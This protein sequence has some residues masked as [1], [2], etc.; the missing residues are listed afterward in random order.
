MSTRTRLQI[1]TQDRSD[2]ANVSSDDDIPEEFSPIHVHHGFHARKMSHQILEPT[3]GYSFVTR[4]Q[5]LLKSIVPITKQSLELPPRKN[6]LMPEK[7][8]HLTLEDDILV[9][10]PVE[11]RMTTRISPVCASVTRS[12]RGRFAF[13]FGSFVQET[14]PK[15]TQSFSTLMTVQLPKGDDESINCEEESSETLETP[16]EIMHRRINEILEGQLPHLDN[17]DIGQQR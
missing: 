9:T 15:S 7:T 17:K 4:N 11:T 10:E 8:R 1:K 2:S 3:K 16:T 14:S 13:T 5:N 12:A 6:R